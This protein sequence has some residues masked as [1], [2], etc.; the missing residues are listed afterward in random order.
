M[1]AVLASVGRAADAGSAMCIRAGSATIGSL[2]GSKFD[3]RSARTPAKRTLTR[4]A[5][6]LPPSNCLS[7]MVLTSLRLLR[8]CGCLRAGS[9]AEGRVSHSVPA[10]ISLCA[11]HSA[12]VQSSRAC[13]ELTHFDFAVQSDSWPVKL[14]VPRSTAHG[15][16]GGAARQRQVRR[17]AEHTAA[18]CA[19]RFEQGL[20]LKGPS[21]CSLQAARDACSHCHPI[22][23][24]RLIQRPNV[25]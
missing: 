17:L 21:C 1:H 10:H 22:V 12:A 25:S 20:P 19:A 18:A 5:V 3:S 2:F 8:R 6:L 9:R 7:I 24:G 23:V 11:L 16:R 15:Q 13:I 4:S 14:H